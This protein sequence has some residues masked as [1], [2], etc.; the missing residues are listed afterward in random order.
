[1]TYKIPILLYHDIESVD[2]PNEKSNLASKETVV[3]VSNF[4]SQIRYLSENNYETISINEYFR[5]IKNEQKSLEGKIII[6]FDDGHYS[7]YKLAF[8]ILVKYGLKATFFITTNWLNQQY[9]LTSDQ[10]KEMI[11]NGMEIGSHGLTH[12][13]FPDMNSH[14]IKF[15]LSESKKILES[16]TKQPIHYIAFPGGHYNR[17]VLRM[18]EMSDYRGA[19]SCLQ[20]LNSKKTNP[21]LLKRIEIRKS[22]S[23]DQFKHIFNPLSIA[24]YQMVDSLKSLTRRTIGLNTYS[25]IRSRLYKYYI[26]KR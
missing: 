11:G 17:T 10:I 15:E 18:L 25:N 22:V 20:G 9:H 2:C 16:I 8:P 19:C 24:F 7:N 3:D 14:E 4:E 12:N 26:F 5:Y 6:S 13:F 1:M 21:W 23:A